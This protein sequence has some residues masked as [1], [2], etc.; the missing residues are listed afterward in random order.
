MHKFTLFFKEWDHPHILLK[1]KESIL[2]GMA[3][4]SGRSTLAFLKNMA[5]NVGG[6]YF[7]LFSQ[8]LYYN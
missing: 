6:Q 2:Y 5:A 1:N 4:H 8:Y 3:Q 7:H